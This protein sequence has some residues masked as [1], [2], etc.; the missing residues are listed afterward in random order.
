MCLR[1][2]VKNTHWGVNNWFEHAEATEKPNLWI[3]MGLRSS[4]L[5]IKSGESLPHLTNDKPK[6]KS[7]ADTF[8][9][10]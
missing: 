3:K 7:Q 1:I 6:G 2:P 4:N 10:V 8:E 9:K 5:G